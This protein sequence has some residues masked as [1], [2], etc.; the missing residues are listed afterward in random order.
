MIFLVFSKQIFQT[1]HLP[2]V[3]E[4]QS[5]P[6]SVPNPGPAPDTLL[7]L[8]KGLFKAPLPARFTLSLRVFFLK[9]RGGHLIVLAT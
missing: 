7:V 6:P 5:V 3:S 4:K 2:G 8:K 9:K 1:A